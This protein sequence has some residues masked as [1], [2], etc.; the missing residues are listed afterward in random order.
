M[1]N[2]QWAGH[3]AWMGEKCLQA[4]GRN[5]LRKETTWKIQMHKGV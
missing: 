1:N 2:M 4:F 5:A 3:V